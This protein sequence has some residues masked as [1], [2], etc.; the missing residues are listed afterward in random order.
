[1]KRLAMILFVLLLAFAVAAQAEETLIDLQFDTGLQGFQTY[2]EGGKCD[3]KQ[4]NGKMVCYIHSCGKVNYA[5]QLYW[6]GFSLVEGCKYVF[7]FDAVCDIERTIEYRMQLN[8]GDYRGYLDEFTVIGPEKQTIRAEF[9]APE[10]DPA[11]RLAFNMGIQEDMDGD[12]GEHIVHIDN[13]R[14]VLVDDSSAVMAEEAEADTVC[15]RV[16]QVGYRPADKKTVVAAERMAGMPFDVVDE[17]SGAVVFSGSFGEAMFDEATQT[18]VC[19]GDFTEVVMEGIYHIAVKAD[20]EERVSYSFT[21][22]ENVYDELFAASVRMLT[23]Q[24]CGDELTKEIGGEFAH[25][26]C[27]VDMAIVYGTDEKRDVSG[28]WHDAGDYGRYVVPGAK[29]AMDLMLTCEMGGAL[30]VSDALGLPESGNGIPDLLDEAR[31]ELEWL[32]KM[33]NEAGGAYHKVSGYNF[34]GTVMPQEETA[35]LV[36]SPVSAAAT[37]DFAAVMAKAAV[38]YKDIDA[39]FAEKCKAAAHSAWVYLMDCG[40][41]TGFTNPADVFTGEYPD[42]IVTDELFFAAAEIMLCDQAAGGET[43]ESVRKVVEE[44]LAGEVIPGL[45]W[46][47]TGAYALYDLAVAEIDPRAA[48]LLA[49]ATDDIVA[50]AEKDGYGCSMGVNYPWGSN[51][52]V[53]GNGMLL[54]MAERVNPGKV[55][56][57]TAKAQLDVLLGL[58]GMDYCYVTGFGTLSTADPHHRPSQAIGHAVPGMLAGGPNMNLEDP[59]AKQVLGGRAPALCYVDSQQSYSTNEVAIYWNSP[60]VFLLGGI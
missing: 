24:R 27:H 44:A 21:V 13:I 16:N 8:G 29:A 37:G 49:A 2:L 60:L 25:P 43:E 58:N 22:A 5:N 34:P 12:P 45:G 3:L 32:F 10:S 47:D 46:I 59:Y 1:M 50:L 55:Y 23:L 11:P 18:N 54:L 57:E 7:E 6:D 33:Q 39:A 17:V 36:L 52:T 9:T 28:G 56:T 51:M 20:D 15:L 48:E 4:E 42:E 53:A 41:L 26:A 30:A 14:L 31:W 38:V 35:Q 19:R 40:E